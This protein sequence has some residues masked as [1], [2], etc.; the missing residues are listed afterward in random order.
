[1]PEFLSEEL[2]AWRAK[3]ERLALEHL[4][5]LR[6]D[7]A[8]SVARRRELTVAASRASGIAA[9][10]QPGHQRSAEP[11]LRL[12]VVRETLARH[13]VGHLPGIF[14]AAPGVL[15][16]VGEPLATTH[17][18]PLLAG[19]KRAGF[20]FTEP[21]DA[22]RPTW[23]VI[24]GDELV[25]TGQKSYVTGGA[26]PGPVGSDGLSGA[27]VIA[28]DFLTATV[29]IEGEGPAMVIIDTDR[30]GVELVR[31][32][33]S[34]DGSGHAAFRFDGVRVPRHCV[35][36][37]PGKG[38]GRALDRIS[39]VRRTIAADC[40]GTA[41][42]VTDL[43]A[44]HLRTPRRDGH[45]PG[46]EQRAR[47]RYGEARAMIYAARATAYRT[48]R[49][50]DAGESAVNESIAAKLV[51]SEVANQVV[52]VAIQLVGGEALIEGHP[53]ETV[54][55][56]LRTLRLAEGESDVLRINIARGHLDLD[57]GRL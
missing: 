48:A 10:T 51:A 6:D 18:A 52:D 53:L 34:F 3:A 23:A 11:E 43:L 8:L 39:E 46:E 21:A 22:P 19:Q 25:I 49:L 54:H 29:D 28:V 16:G 4:V 47:L 14:G 42:W 55:R 17:L 1:M 33:T 27:P 26:D 31:R 13:G 30:P 7:P 36:G 41:M 32:F 50:V 44:R 56:R 12:L 2:L 24:D 5:A 35:V 15:A 57:Q 9:L 20:A 45:R 37:P 38:L 40:V